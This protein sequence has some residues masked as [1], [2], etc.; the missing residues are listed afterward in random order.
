MGLRYRFIADNPHGKASS[1][2]GSRFS[3][4]NVPVLFGTAAL[5]WDE[6]RTTQTVALVEGEI[7]AMS[8][9]QVTGWHVF[10]YGSEGST[11]LHP[12]QIR[13]LNQYKSVIVWADKP[14]IARKL[15]AQLPVATA[16]QSPQ[17]MDANDLLLAGVLAPLLKR[18]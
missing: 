2:Y 3:L 14:N 6:D 5:D 18:M 17:G 4:N 15:Q 7:N 11:T 10:S 8:I 1:E 16:M 9:H 12:K 13:F